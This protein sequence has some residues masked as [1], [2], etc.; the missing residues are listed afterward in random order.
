MIPKGLFTQIGMLIVSV[1]I[2]FTYIKPAFG[3][4]AAIQD[5]IQTYQMERDKVISVNS[6]LSKLVTDMESVSSEDQRKL[7]T[8]LPDS[9]DGIN[10]SR[11]LFLITLQSGVLY[12]DVRDMGLV[13]R[14]SKNNRVEDS[15]EELGP[16]GH[17]FGLSVEGTYDQLKNLFRLIEQNNY[18]LE[19]QSVSIDKLDGGFLGAEITFVTY[20][21]RSDI[22]SEPVF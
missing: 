3:E 20:S 6:L 18:P 9:V 19:V 21:F 8:Y 5:N 22:T 10:V 4:V 2:I 14:G 11:D 16:E 1:G 7:L 17:Q 13:A 12:K 15:E